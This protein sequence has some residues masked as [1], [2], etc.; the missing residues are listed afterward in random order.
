MVEALIGTTKN[1]VQSY[2]F[3]VKYR[4]NS[5]QCSWNSWYYIC[6]RDPKTCNEI[7]YSIT[8]FIRLFLWKIS[9]VMHYLSFVI[10][11]I[12][13]KLCIKA[14]L[15]R[16]KKLHYFPAVAFS[17]AAAAFFSCFSLMIFASRSFRCWKKIVKLKIKSNYYYFLANI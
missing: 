8:N 4:K 17:A 9:S 6:S 10:T 3:Y 12:G 5:D 2:P 11:F 1:F 15:N 13:Q 7:S 16:K 14:S